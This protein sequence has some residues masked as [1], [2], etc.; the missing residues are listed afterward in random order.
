M[1]LKAFTPWL[2]DVIRKICVNNNQRR[3]KIGSCVMHIKE[4]LA[5]EK[6]SSIQFTAYRKIQFG[7]QIY[8][9][10]TKWTEEDILRSLDTCLHAS[11]HTFGANESK[12][13]SLKERVHA[14]DGESN[15]FV[16]GDSKW[17]YPVW[18]YFSDNMFDFS[19]RFRSISQCGSM[20]M[21]VC[22]RA[23]IRTFLSGCHVCVLRRICEEHSMRTN[24]EYINIDAIAWTQNFHIAIN[25]IDPYTIYIHAAWLLNGK[26]SN[27]AVEK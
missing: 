6:I 1:K 14:I 3:G 9:C 27:N 5:R 21:Y 7:W 19:F 2:C 12:Y 26:C 25:Q 8:R 11:R 15:R 4:R 22:V 16:R 17:F 10:A 18:K 13:R 23:C 24:T 20:H